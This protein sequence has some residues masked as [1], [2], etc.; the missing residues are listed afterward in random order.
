MCIEIGNH[1]EGLYLDPLNALLSVF[2]CRCFVLVERALK[3]E[4]LQLT[5]FQVRTRRLINTW[6]IERASRLPSYKCD[7]NVF[8]FS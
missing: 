7:E 6:R 3:E 4:L 8:E 1:V 2:L 5:A